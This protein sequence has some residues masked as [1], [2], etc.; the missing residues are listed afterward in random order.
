MADN[1][2]DKN[3]K[4]KLERDGIELVDPLDYKIL[5]LLPVEGTTMSG[6]YPL[7][8]LV[9]EVSRTLKIPSGVA[10]GRVRYMDYA[11]LVKQ[12]KALGSGTAKHAWQRTFLGDK[13]LTEWRDSGNDE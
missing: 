7:G 9:K 4:K 2:V 11:G 3:I 5:E 8:T 10:T 13:Y 1:P 6:L 12:I